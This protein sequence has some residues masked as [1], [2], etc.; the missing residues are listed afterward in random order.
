MDKILY[1]P[2]ANNG[3]GE[4]QARVIEKMLDTELVLYDMT[5]IESYTD[6]FAGLS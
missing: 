2:H 1:N 3:H 5:K 4:E 6:F